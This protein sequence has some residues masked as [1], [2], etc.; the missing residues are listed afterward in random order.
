MGR[1]EEGG[2]NVELENIGIQRGRTILASPLH[3][4]CCVYV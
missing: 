2:M 1:I 4:H 3:G